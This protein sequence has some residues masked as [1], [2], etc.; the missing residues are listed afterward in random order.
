M[1]VI[2]VEII[3]QRLRLPY[4]MWLLYDQERLNQS[5]IGIRVQTPLFK[6]DGD[7]HGDH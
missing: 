4:N 6:S 2:V 1:C 5:F 7:Y 3:Y